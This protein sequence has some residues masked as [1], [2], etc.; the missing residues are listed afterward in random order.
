MSKP[1][2]DGAQ[3]SSPTRQLFERLRARTNGST[4]FKE[5]ETLGRGGMG[6]VLCVE[7]E[8]LRRKLAMKVMREEDLS[9]LSK[10]EREEA[11]LDRLGRFFGEARITG[12]LDHPGIVPVHEVGVDDRDRP[13]FTMK[14]VRG[15]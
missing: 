11:E 3:R 13:Y 14:R 5:I 12:Q 6:V 7:D 9:D 8:D 2:D 1:D 15:R 4:R 10:E